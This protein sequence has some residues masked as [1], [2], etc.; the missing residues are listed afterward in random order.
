MLQVMEDDPLHVRC[1]QF[2]RASPLVPPWV[3]PVRQRSHDRPE[4]GQRVLAAVEEIQKP[5]N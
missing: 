1:P 4:A 3:Q 5:E 2:D